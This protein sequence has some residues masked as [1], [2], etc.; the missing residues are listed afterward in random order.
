MVKFS[1][2]TVLQRNLEQIITGKK[3]FIPNNSTGVVFKTIKLRNQ[4]NKM[5]FEEFIHNQVRRLI[6]LM[7][8][9]FQILI[10]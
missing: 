5:S 9:I 6:Y 10:F 7:V 1:N 8:K 2:E 3:T 4:F